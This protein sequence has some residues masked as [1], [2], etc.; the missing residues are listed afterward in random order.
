[1]EL[2]LEH[3]S[4]EYKNTTALDDFSMTFSEGIY[5]LLGPNGAGKSTLMKLITRNIKPTTG[6]IYLDETNIHDLKREYQRLI[7]YMPQQQEIYPFYTGRMFLAY[8]GLL[9]GVEKKMLNVEIEKYASKVNLLDVLDRKVGTY[10]GGM[11]QRLLIAQAFLGDSKIIIF[12]E[13]TAGLDPKERI[14]VRNLIHDNSAGKIILIATHV[15][16]DIED[17]ASQIML[18]KKGVLIEMAAPEILTGRITDKE[19]PDLE[20]VYLSIFGE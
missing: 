19:N 14:H 13:P 7:G 4:K 5:G 8:M 16:Q 1:M 17:I 20:D 12:D 15:V 3:I 6:E 18:L 9:K 10:S 2:K 11:K